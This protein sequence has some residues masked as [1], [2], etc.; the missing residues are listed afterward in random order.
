[1]VLYDLA[2][3]QTLGSPSDDPEEDVLFARQVLCSPADYGCV[4]S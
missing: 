1:M 4:P 2:A 3:G